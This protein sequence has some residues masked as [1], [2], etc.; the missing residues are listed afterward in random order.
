MLIPLKGVLELQRL[1]DE[2]AEGEAGDATPEIKI[3]AERARTRSSSCAGFEFS[4]KLVD[5]QFPP[6]QQVIPRAQRAASRACRACAS[7]T[8]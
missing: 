7:P 3:V 2:A 6:Y 5:A 4:V 8:R 1:C